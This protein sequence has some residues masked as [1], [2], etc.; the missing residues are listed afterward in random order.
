MSSDFI[1]L[2]FVV[3]GLF[4]GLLGGLL[5]IG[6]GVITVPILYFVFQYTAIFGDKTMEVAVSTSLAA[7]FVTSAVSTFIQ[8][9]KKAIVFEAIKKLAPGLI[10]GCILGS[11]IAHYLPNDLLSK[12][13]GM[14][15]ILLGLYFFFPRL[16]HLYISSTPNQS[17]SLFGLIIG[18]L[19]SLLGIGGGSLAFPILLG[20]QIPVKNA[21]ATSSASTL[22]T[23]I[24]GS[25]TYLAIGW[26]QP[27]LPST[28]GYIELP[29]F[30]AIS[31]G[32]MISAP[33]GVKLSH[34]LNV[35]HIKQIFGC[36]LAL[37]GLSML[38]L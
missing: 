27:E 30:I 20:Y 15:A 9:K 24:L 6:G 16:P 2:L 31:I 3:L 28:F 10:I 8:W 38:I 29:A 12:I 23:T 22:A 11:L 7:G 32:S 4:S 21:S 14:M 19:S 18:C 26:N 17:L 34:V 5:G 1:L 13:F 36:S 37:V 35:A 25:M 33:F